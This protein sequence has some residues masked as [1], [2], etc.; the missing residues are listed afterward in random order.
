MR[1]RIYSTDNPITTD[2]LALRKERAFVRYKMSRVFDELEGT[3]PCSRCSPKTPFNLNTEMER[4]T[5]RLI[6]RVRKGQKRPARSQPRWEE[7]DDDDKEFR[8]R[9]ALGNEELARMELVTYPLFEWLF[10]RFAHTGNLS[11]VPEVG[12]RTLEI[13]V[14]PINSRRIQIVSG[15]YLGAVIYLRDHR[16]TKKSLVA[17]RIYDDFTVDVDGRNVEL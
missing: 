6:R 10:E 1:R 9:M 16:I 14:E 17:L 8:I 2:E 4:L 11:G 7:L 15:N 3:P 5:K 13:E 12:T